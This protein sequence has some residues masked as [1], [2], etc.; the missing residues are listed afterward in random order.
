MLQNGKNNGDYSIAQ[1]SSLNPLDWAI[2][3]GQTYGSR[4][5]RS[6]YNGVEILEYGW[7]RKA[8]Q[9]SCVDLVVCFLTVGYTVFE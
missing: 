3:S 9:R 6:G 4:T 2:D 5:Q 7:V 1:T 8:K